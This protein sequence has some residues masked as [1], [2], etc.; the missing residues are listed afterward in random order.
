MIYMY[1]GGYLCFR[2][3]RKQLKLSSDDGDSGS[4]NVIGDMV[5]PM[6]ESGGIFI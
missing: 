2:A 1:E 6:M 4:M 3:M 5:A